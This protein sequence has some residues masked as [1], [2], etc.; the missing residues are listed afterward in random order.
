MI[1]AKSHW[2]GASAFAIAVVLAPAMAK[3]Q[4]A[5]CTGFS[6]P[7][8]A[9]V[10]AMSGPAKVTA[11]HEAK[12]VAFAEQPIAMA[13]KPSKTVTL[14]VPTEIKRQAIGADTFSG[15]IELAAVP[16]PGLYQV[17]LSL[18]AWIDLVQGGNRLQSSGF[19]GRRE[20]ATLRKS[21][22]FHIGAGPVTIQLSGAPT[23]TVKVLIS[24]AST[25]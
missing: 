17:S 18:D 12:A 5:G 4:D 8:E 25:P 7:L 14:P 19:T 13:L 16:A 20:C 3:A 24:K 10:K 9:E 11:A 21:V 2:A 22:R 15:W 1:R 6:W 23:D